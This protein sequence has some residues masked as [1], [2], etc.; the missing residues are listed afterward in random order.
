MTDFK[1]LS[2]INQK[3]VRG[4]IRKALYCQ[5]D[6]VNAY[7]RLAVSELEHLK[8]MGEVRNNL[9]INKE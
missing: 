4:L 9:T 7:L 3:R 6:R 2:P 8:P 5:P 1:D